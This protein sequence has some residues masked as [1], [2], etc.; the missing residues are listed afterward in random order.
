MNGRMGE[1]LNPGGQGLPTA[2]LKAFPL[3]VLVSSH[4][5]LL[6]RE[7][8]MT[9]SFTKNTL[10]STKKKLLVLFVKLCVSSVY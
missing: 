6:L 2:A 7:I 1:W 5:T 9:Q 3:T 10:R 4:P 8:I